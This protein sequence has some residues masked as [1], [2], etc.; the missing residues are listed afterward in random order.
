MSY[1]VTT[2]GHLLHERLDFIEHAVCSF[3]KLVEGMVKS[4]REQA[5]SQIAGDDA[6]DHCVEFLH[7]F[8]GAGAQD[9][10]NYQAQAQ[11]EG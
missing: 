5:L 7:A 3:S 10:A 4:L 1:F 11:G 6:A 9:H 8:L 2:P